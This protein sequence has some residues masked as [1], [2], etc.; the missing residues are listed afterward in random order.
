MRSCVPLLIQ[1]LFLLGVVFI[2]LSPIDAFSA[3]F[4]AIFG[5]MALGEH[6]PRTCR[7]FCRLFNIF[8]SEMRSH[9]SHDDIVLPYMSQ[10]QFMV[11]LVLSFYNAMMRGLRLSFSAY[12]LGT[13]ILF[14]STPSL[15]II[16]ML[17]EAALATSLLNVIRASAQTMAIDNSALQRMIAELE[18]ERRDIDNGRVEPRISVEGH[19]REDQTWADGAGD[20]EFTPFSG[21]GFSISCVGQMEPQD[22][23]EE[24]C[25][26]G[27]CRRLGWKKW[28]A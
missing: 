21:Q 3:L 17:C 4:V 9:G 28:G 13:G 10:W 11:L 16:I 24:G 25:W 15:N 7:S 23:C 20:H 8:W 27:C 2:P 12:R 22:S 18:Q 6:A 5:T 14:Y 1:V 19:R 26:A